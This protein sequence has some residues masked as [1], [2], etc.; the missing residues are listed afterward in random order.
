MR[1]QPVFDNTNFKGKFILDCN[2]SIEQIKNLRKVTENINISSKKYNVCV[3]NDIRYNHLC[4]DGDSY[5]CVEAVN[6]QKKQKFGVF[7]AP[8]YQKDEKAIE[9]KINKAINGFENKYNSLWGKVKNIF[10]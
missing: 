7:V 1:I 10:K 9:E 6:P 3:F 5:I 8:Q 2:L 4:H